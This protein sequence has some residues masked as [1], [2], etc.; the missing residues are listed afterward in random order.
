MAWVRR[1]EPGNTPEPD[2]SGKW[3]ACDDFAVQMEA[4][5][6]KRGN[7]DADSTDDEGTTATQ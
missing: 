4:V 5:R 7:G 1:I 2:R 6:Q 3:T